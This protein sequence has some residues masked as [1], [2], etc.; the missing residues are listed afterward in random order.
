MNLKSLL[1]ILPT[2]RVD[3]QMDHINIHSIEIDHRNI[4][5]GDLF[6][7]I[8][9]FTVD[10]HDFAEKAVENGAVAILSEKILENISVPVIIVK[11][12]TRSLAMI[13]ANFYNY[14]SHQLS[15]IGITGTNGKTTIT[16]LLEAIFQEHR[17]KTGLMGT[18]Q[19]KIGDDSFPVTNTT[20]N[21]LF[22]QKSL[23]E[24]VK[25]QVDV[26]MMEV[27]S[28]ALD[29]GRVFGCNFNVAV[30]TNLSQDHL[31][32]HK[33]I[34]DYLRAKSLLFAQLGNDYNI[35]DKK[36]AIINQ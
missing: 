15:L 6:V 14:P 1:S 36:Y 22:V 20:P 3:Q 33:S 10:G 28:H 16:Y 35:H 11:D 17:Q 13:A 21:A 23:H 4:Q 18:I 29:L 19:M 9:G 25:Q 32:Y 8:R 7:C 34:D 30:Y 27:S 26:A 5:S 2:Y 24:M 12:T 31:D